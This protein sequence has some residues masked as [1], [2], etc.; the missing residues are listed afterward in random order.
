VSLHFTRGKVSAGNHVLYDGLSL[1]MT[2]GHRLV[3]QVMHSS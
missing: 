1:T 3:G 2:T